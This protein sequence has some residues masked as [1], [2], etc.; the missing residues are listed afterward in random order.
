M[1]E[2]L[3][4]EVRTAPDGAMTMIELPHGNGLTLGE[5]YRI[6]MRR[7]VRFVVLAGPSGSGKTTLVTTIYHMLQ[8]GPLAGYMFAGS[9]TLLG[10]EQRGYLARTVSEGP[11]PQS[12]KT[13]RGISDAVL[14]LK[15]Y[16]VQTRV[17]QD[18]LIADFSGED[19]RSA[20]GNVDLVRSEFSVIRRADHI[21]LL[22]D[23][24]LISQKKT[25]YGTEQEALQ[26]L[27]TLVDANL[28]GQGTSVGILISK[29]D[30]VAHRA[31]DDTAIDTFVQACKARFNEEFGQQLI[32]HHLCIAAMPENAEELKV[33]YGLN[34]LLPAW[35]TFH[36]NA[37]SVLPNE[38]VSGD[39]SEFNSF[40]KRMGTGV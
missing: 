33:G 36:D 29:Y 30:L 23:G 6:T 31:K 1:G 39:T 10:F 35:V 21:A 16:D 26:L 38:W 40:A 28:V 4:N 14:H 32:M 25:R 24:D 9:E 13:R 11:S 34:E 22:I 3:P 20:I 5:T 27:K 12:A 37:G 7:R 18:V 15:L 17:S 8:K 19:Y 2:N